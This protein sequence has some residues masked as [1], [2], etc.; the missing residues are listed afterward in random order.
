[1]ADW[2]HTTALCI[3]L[4]VFAFKVHATS[5]L[6]GSPRK[7]YDMLA[8]QPPVV[9]NAGGSYTTF[10]SIPGLQF[11]VINIIGNLAAVF[12]DQ[13]YFNRAISAK[14]E[15]AVPAYLL[16]G[17]AWCAIPLTMASSLG[18]AARAMVGQVPSMVN[19]TEDQVRAGLSAP[20]AAVALM[21]PAGA[22]IILVLLFLAVTS[23]TSAELLAVASLAP[24]DIWKA[25]VRPKATER[26]LSVV[27]HAFIVGWAIIMAA[28]A[29]MFYEIKI[30]LGWLYL[31]EDELFSASQ[32][33][34]AGE[35]ARTESFGSLQRLA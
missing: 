34:P 35:F 5:P 30:S 23:S 8:M 4:L 17:A 14:P 12:A 1:M 3:I 28:L 18:L 27:S 33:P 13:G 21:G 26:E 16:A 10:R 32:P 11:G 24:F 7:L 6:I 15:A 20:A 22:A 29:L 31:G 19:L 25:Y 9:G 2:L